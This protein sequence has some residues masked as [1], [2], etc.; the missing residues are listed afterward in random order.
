MLTKNHKLHLLVTGVVLSVI[1]SVCAQEDPDPLRFQKQIET[2]QAWDRKNAIPDDFVLMIGSSSIVMW[3]SMESFP[4]LKIVNRG[5]GG[6][7]ISDLIHYK[8]EILLKYE[9]PQCIVFY[10][11]DNDVASGKSPESVLKDFETFWKVV[12]QH[13]PNTPLVYIPIKPCPSRWHLWEKASKFNEQIRV[14]SQENSW[15][16]YADTA[17]PMLET[18]A[19][20]DSSLFISDMLHLSGK[21][22]AMWTSVVRP[23][24]DFGIRQHVEATRPDRTQSGRTSVLKK[25]LIFCLIPIKL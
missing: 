17:E 7:H 15:L 1:F 19:P 8:Q 12:R 3:S 24:V 21:G 22:Y 18:G 23:I 11:G 13:A 14:L 4:D 9:T 16:Y 2:F 5:F 10:C 25:Q 20:P 6:S